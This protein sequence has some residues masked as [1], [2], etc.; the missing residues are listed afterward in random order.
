MNNLRRRT[1]LLRATWLL[2]CAGLASWSGPAG[3][4]PS[5][6][7]V[8]HGDVGIGDGAG[9]N[10]QIDQRSANAIIDWEDFSIDAGEL[11]QF[12]Q[13]GSSAAALNRVTGGDPSAIHGALR[14]N[15]NVFL[16]NPN[17]I[18]VGP[19]GSID[20]HGLALSTLDI[21][22]GEFLAGGD[23]VFQGQG[24][25]D[26]TNM[27]RI[28]A[29]GGDVFLIGQNVA[30]SGTISATGTVGLAAGEEVL[31]TAGEGAEG[32]RM[33]VRAG[34]SGGGTGVLNDG[35][36][37][38]A[39]VELKAHGNAY[40]LAINNQGSIRAT[41]AAQSGGRVFLRG[42]G[43]TVRNSGTIRAAG[44]DPVQA[45]RAL[46]EAAHARVDGEI[47]AE[48][49]G[50]V[51]VS[52]SDTAEIDG[53]LQATSS[54]A[55][56]GAIDVEGREVRL[57]SRARLDAGG[58]SGGGSVR[59]GGGA[60]GGAD[61]L[62]NAATTTVAEGARVV[63]DATG[64]GDGG[65][66]VVWSDEET[67]YRGSI[68]AAARESGE[69][70]FVE[71]SGKKR[72]H[73]AGSV[74]T[75]GAGGGST[76]TLLLD[77]ND[78][79]V[80]GSSTV[81]SA[82]LVTPGSI[83]TALGSNNVVI[84]TNGSETDSGDI[85]I[86]ADV[87]YGEANNLSFLATRHIRANA[88]V[89]N[90]GGGD[91]NL[92]AGWD[93]STGVAGGTGASGNPNADDA[94]IAA[95]ESAAAF[96]LDAGSGN[97]SIFIGDGA[98]TDGISVGS[99]DGITNVLG[100]G[101]EV[102]AG[103]ATDAY[104]HLG[105]RQTG[106]S[107][108]ASGAIDVRTREGGIL[109]KSASAGG[110]ASNRVQH[111]YA[112]IGHGGVGLASVDHSGAI[113]LDT[114]HGATD[115][116]V[117]LRGGIADHGEQ[118]WTQVGHGGL[119]AGGTQS[120]D[121]AVT[122]GDINLGLPGD[123]GSNRRNSYAHI[124]HGG[125]NADGNKSGA[126]DIVSSGSV[127]LTAAPVGST[128]GSNAQI[129]HGGEDSSGATTGA[130]DIELTDGGSLEVLGGN[131]L[132]Y[133]QVGHGGRN[134]GGGDIDGTITTTGA[135]DVAVSGGIHDDTYG[136]I[137]HGG[138]SGGSADLAGI[139]ELDASGDLAITGGGGGNGTKHYA[140]IG[141][142]GTGVG[143][144]LSG[145]IT[146]NVGGDVILAGGTQA[147][148]H[149]AI[150]HVAPDAGAGSTLD[151]DIALTVAGQL[152]LDGGTVEGTFAQVGHGGHLSSAGVDAAVTVDAVR[153]TGDGGSGDGAYV[154]IGHGGFNETR[155]AAGTGL[156]AGWAEATRSGD[157]SVTSTN[158]FDFVGGSGIG[159]Y[160]Q[161]GHGGRRNNAVAGEGHSGA[162]E[163]I[164]KSID[165]FGGSGAESYGMVGHGGY[166]TTGDHA[167][168]V[169]VETTGPNNFGGRIRLRPDTA[170]NDDADRAF[171]QVGHG[172]FDADFD[173]ADLVTV[174][175]I[176]SQPYYVDNRAASLSGDVTVTSNEYVVLRAVDSNTAQE[177]Y[178]QIGHGGFDTTGSFGLASDSVEVSAQANVE[179]LASQV[180]AA[181]D[182]AARGNYA[183]IGH[184]G[185]VNV[186]TATADNGNVADPNLGVAATG[187][188]AADVT[189]SAT[190]GRIN[191]SA[192][193]DDQGYAQIGHGGVN[194]GA[195]GGHSGDISVTATGADADLLVLGGR[196]GAPD[197]YSL[198]GHG[199]INANGD[200][201]G[202]VAVEAGRDV[203]VDSGGAARTFAQIGH[204][205]HSVNGNLGLDSDDLFVTADRDVLLRTGANDT[206]SMIGLGGYQSTGIHSVNDINVSAAGD[207]GLDVGSNDAFA[208][209][210]LGGF[211][212]Q[213]DPDGS[214]TANEI[215][216]ISSG[217]AITVAGGNGTD[218]F[219]HL[220]LGGRL[221][222][223][224][225]SAA[226][227]TVSALND[228]TVT[229][230]DGA[231]AYA[232]IGNGGH[233][234]YG[235]LFEG[236]ISVSSADG[237][238]SVRGS[239]VQN[240]SFAHIGHGGRFEKS[241][242]NYASGVFS[243]EIGIDT[244]TDVSVLGGGGTSYGMV[245]HG[246]W[247]AGRSSSAFSGS[248]DIDA[249]QDVNV[250]GG[251]F[252]DPVAAIG[253]SNGFAKIGHGGTDSDGNHSGL[254]RVDADRDV[255]VEGG[256][257]VDQTDTDQY[258]QIGHGGTLH[259]GTL[260]GRI[261]I[262]QDGG[263]G[264]G[265]ITFLG[266]DSDSS[267]A[268]L[269]HGGTNA[270]G[271]RSG[272]IVA[273]IGG[274]ALVQAG[275]DPGTYAAIGHGAPGTSGSRS[276]A[277]ELRVGGETSL[278][279]NADPSSNR[280]WHIGHR[281]SGTIS[282]A[283]VLFL[284]G[285]LD[286]NAGSVATDAT[287][288]QNFADIFTGNLAGGDVTVGSTSAAPAE[289]SIEGAFGYTSSSDLTF[290]SAGN[291][292]FDDGVQNA[293][294]GAVN[295][296]A[297]WDGS[298]GLTGTVGTPPLFDIL[299]IAADPSSFGNGGGSLFVGDGLQSQR[300]SVGSKDG[301]TN[302]AG[303]DVTILSRD[304]PNQNNNSN[305]HVGYFFGN[306]P[307]A[308][309]ATGA[310]TIGA[311][312]DFNLRAGS[313]G[314]GWA[315][316]GHGG[317]NDA[318]PSSAASFSGDI[319]VTAGND[320]LVSGLT[321][322]V[323]GFRSFAQVGHGGRGQGGTHSG[324]I[325]IDAGNELRLRGG[326]SG[327]SWTFAQVGHGGAEAPGDFSGA[328]QADADSIVIEGGGGS[329]AYAQLGHGGIDHTGA[330]DG[331]IEI[332]QD[333][334]P[335]GGAITLTGGD[336]SRSYAQLGHGGTN[337]D[338]AVGSGITSDI[339]LSM[340][341][342][343][344]LNGGSSGR[345]YAQIGHGGDN[346]SGSLLGDISVESTGADL[347]RL[348]AGQR[349]RQR[350]PCLRPDRSR[351]RREQRHEG[352][353]HRR[354]RGG[355][356][357]YARRQSKHR[358]LRPDRPR[359]QRFLRRRRRR[360][361]QRRHPPGRWRHRAG[362]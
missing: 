269:G 86:N 202:T 51:R 69:G 92:V 144:S 184:G 21:D 241:A 158:D 250:R 285:A 87:T 239:T 129:G 185:A 223:G 266:G 67:D 127:R 33:F 196:G 123:T 150:G 118:T 28:N 179:I 104:A 230:G 145:A 336:G 103:T 17:G 305:A 270:S 1:R 359:R 24:S 46:I 175:D 178:A 276:G 95:I 271:N 210:G 141:H 61:D 3:A 287:I 233:E 25:G 274:D 242:S 257:T 201:A 115:G 353:R 109:A 163:L 82:S 288:D 108:G 254:I 75:L 315:Q 357:H 182:L 20:V 23:R 335:A 294:D 13:P 319:A 334:G 186:S 219:A 168:D 70:G 177:A 244:G 58:A 50:E 131:R 171:V 211:D 72:L 291:V 140:Q 38:G 42:S 35:S 351:R 248:I 60:H 161:I 64:S 312:N 256:G 85:F 153:I 170:G 93:E 253:N 76:G 132:S 148:T 136:Q 293:G 337:H 36:I 325:D 139:I 169:F 255:L 191:L 62:A 235:G 15:G 252:D 259:N 295:G 43:G 187:S 34:G 83:T 215:N 2:A 317:N 204:G 247:R 358:L 200:H 101:L 262:N 142:G 71:V 205:G 354:Q 333:G 189:V 356:G 280:V 192:G 308:V 133:A 54:D 99:R 57:G 29:I 314:R 22:N 113:T 355:G 203:R 27:G 81:G 251:G 326:V 49:G 180:G 245:G 138:V 98:Q 260:D 183:Q 208:M 126:I 198:I 362:R 318:A 10:L 116:A 156:R 311:I 350:G 297:G 243:G 323:G 122:G 149:A 88:D 193:V 4:N 329:N 321:S 7:V 218:R 327:S 217:G 52:G 117:T 40:A 302:L 344:E 303:F 167:G 31:V 68:S 32:E 299:P 272:A 157:V 166:Q 277:I 154:Q 8:V 292:Q 105:Y 59:I 124:G 263:L 78:V 224:D 346:A 102:A 44:G 284:T 195:G 209:I 6:G 246:G 172:G 107:D 316:V 137:G 313:N 212:G 281:T 306:S 39:A 320:V 94:D 286:S 236:D 213:R 84:S 330:L 112:L 79:E 228:I 164:G 146:A 89:Q 120:G 11:T 128:A 30:N 279:D 114:T 261:E 206:F 298:T 147:G 216:V 222:E 249:G 130:I 232:M 9:G 134:R 96:G 340:A 275:T 309:T 289:L 324:L 55:R 162:I 151:G 48:N 119:N 41:G 234:G 135:S 91:V 143:G 214:L 125:R 190:G 110:T 349:H 165:L 345:T 265:D 278:V 307:G 338:G 63:A 264:Q 267:Y 47:A 304:D 339:T 341:G 111:A 226:A 238:I 174:A 19:G 220:G 45:A 296:V 347:G 73:F 290:L 207:I 227:I 268:Q 14:A 77:P 229:A 322:V 237:A 90:S 18:L 300:I 173:T 348:A 231:R 332:N 361:D 152:D 352:W 199:G 282:N 26:V 343:I 283:E 37:E 328:I 331:S 159:A 100:H 160:V 56:G 360:G 301:Q 5:G 66:V 221:W 106:G 53:S 188:H 310:I 74:S 80:N 65:R 181:T 194:N 273:S 155:D 225:K 342:A 240:Q 258:A 12:N 16:I 97:G 176:G 197:G 121:I